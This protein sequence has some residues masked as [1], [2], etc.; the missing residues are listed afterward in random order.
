MVLW[1]LVS[2]HSTMHCTA[3]PCWQTKHN[4]LGVA[5]RDDRIR[6]HCAT[7]CIQC[8]PE[9]VCRIPSC[10]GVIAEGS[11]AYLVLLVGRT[12][13]TPVTMVSSL[14]S[15]APPIP[16]Q[17]S[18]HVDRGSFANRSFR[19]HMVIFPATQDSI[20]QSAPHAVSTSAGTPFR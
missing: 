7:V 5:L 20:K 11:P 18:L 2:P 15:P 3:I 6:N 9:S 10:V 19:L 14:R 13:I 16:R 17:H 1:T 8:H 12:F 4:T